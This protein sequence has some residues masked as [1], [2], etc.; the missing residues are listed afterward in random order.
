MM[1]RSMLLQPWG[2]MPSYMG[3]VIR[4]GK[5]IRRLNETHRIVSGAY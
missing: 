3:K 1:T 5:V 2:S 4:L